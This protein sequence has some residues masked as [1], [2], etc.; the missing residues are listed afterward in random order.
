MVFDYCVPQ[1]GRHVTTMRIIESKRMYIWFGVVDIREK[2]RE[3]SF[4]KKNCITFSFRTG[5]VATSNKWSRNKV[6]RM[7][8][9]H[10]IRMEIDMDKNSIVWY[11]SD[12]RN[13]IAPIPKL[14]KKLNL[15]PYF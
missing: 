10:S 11:I 5:H 1:S 3:E 2:D 8:V 14:M 4:N 12:G 13:S 6:G 9:G 7:E 15:A